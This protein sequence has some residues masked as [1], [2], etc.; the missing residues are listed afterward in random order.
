MDIHESKIRIIC[1]FLEIMLLDGI[2]GK[3][4]DIST[5]KYCELRIKNQKRDLTY[6]P[7]LWLKDQK[8][9]K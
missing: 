8:S 7:S 5:C 3:K 4:H 2:G 6:N 1:P 9:L